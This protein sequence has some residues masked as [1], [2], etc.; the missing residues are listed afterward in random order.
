MRGI[1][2]VIVCEWYILMCVGMF[3]CLWCLVEYIW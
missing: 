1:K 3:V 2:V